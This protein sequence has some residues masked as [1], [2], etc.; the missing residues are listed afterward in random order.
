MRNATARASSASRTRSVHPLT[1][2]LGWAG[3]GLLVAMLWL[4]QSGPSQARLDPYFVVRG[5]AFGTITPRVLFVLDTSLSEE[6][7]WR[8]YPHYPIIQGKYH[9]A[10]LE[11]AQ[12]EYASS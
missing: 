2:L 9:Q 3:F 11:L 10:N 8:R 12:Q 1:R 4:G 5:D 6:E 7:L